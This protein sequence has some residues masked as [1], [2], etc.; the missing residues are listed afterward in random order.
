MGQGRIEKAARSGVAIALAA[1]AMLVAASPASAALSY[2]ESAPTSTTAGNQGNSVVDCP[3]SSFA[4]GGGAFSTGAYGAVAI[5]GSIPNMKTRWF[6]FTD[7]YTGTQAH[8]AFAICDSTEPTLR[9]NS[10]NSSEAGQKTV[11][12]V[13]PRRQHVYG[14]GFFSGGDV[15]STTT[16]ASR[17]FDGA[18]AGKVRDDGWEAIAFF[19]NTALNNPV[20]AYALCGPKK[21]SVRTATVDVNPLSQ[22]FVPKRCASGERVTGGGAYIAAGHGKGW[23]SSTYPVDSDADGVTDDSWAAFFENTTS[24]KRAITVYAICR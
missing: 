10:K 11:H 9:T 20:T 5:N 23:I 8:R 1:A 3:P 7:V 12:A 19:S 15:G 2:V 22:G 17:P 21:P 13:C 24:T 14:G 4:I 16:R 18:D 6:E